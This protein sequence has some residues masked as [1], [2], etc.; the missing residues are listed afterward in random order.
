MDFEWNSQK[1]DINLKKHDVSFQEASAVFGD[2]LS[3]T[4][5]DSGHSIQEK[6]YIIIGLSSKNRV[7]VISHTYR[8]ETIRIISARQATK[9]ERD[10]YESRK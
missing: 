4:Y 3:F 10:F 1:A 2:Y 6:R 9:R 5:P 7:L 8:G